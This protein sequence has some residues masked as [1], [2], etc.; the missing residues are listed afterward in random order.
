MSSYGSGGGSDSGGI[1]T[2]YGVTIDRAMQSND[3]NQLKEVLRA[4]RRYFE[5]TRPHVMYGVVIDQAIQSGASREELQS[6][7]EAA[8]AT[9]QSDLKG[10]I[11]RL[12]AHL[13]KS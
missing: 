5:D 4:V 6:L 10:A 3:I 8:K 11:S 7:L 2:L 12:E 9:H 1:H 13:G